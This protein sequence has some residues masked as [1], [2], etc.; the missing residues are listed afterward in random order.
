LLKLV[1]NLECQ[2]TF[3]PGPNNPQNMG[4]RIRPKLGSISLTLIGP[5]IPFPGNENPE[6]RIPKEKLPN[7]P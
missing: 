2:G 5:P 6:L 7:I 4:P 1:G 3:L